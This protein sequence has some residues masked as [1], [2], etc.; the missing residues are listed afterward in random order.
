MRVHQGRRRHKVTVVILGLLAAATGSSGL[1]QTEVSRADSPAMSA[2]RPSPARP[3]V[4]RVLAFE[5]NDGQIDGAARFIAH[6]RGAT[7]FLTTSGLVVAPVEERG[8]RSDALRMTLVGAST[9]G[10]FTVSQPLQGRANY[11]VG[12]D[13]AKWRTGIPT[14]DRVTERAV[15]PGIDIAYYGVDGQVEY[16]FLVAPGADPGA[17]ELS[18]DGAERISLD[19]AG[20]LVLATTQGTLRVKAPQAYQEHVGNR[21]H[22]DA[23]FV[24]RANTVRFEVGAF[25]RTQTLVIDPVIAYSSY[26]GGGND[27]GLNCCGHTIGR[28]IKTDAA[29]NI[30]ITGHQVQNNAFP[31]TITHGTEGE[32][33]VTKFTPD[34]ATLLFSAVIGGTGSDHALDMTVDAAGNAYVVGQS[35]SANDFPITASAFQQTFGGVQDAVV[36]KLSPDGSSLLYSSFLGG[37]GRDG[38]RRIAIDPAGNAYVMGEPAAGFPLVGNPYQTT[39]PGQSDLFVAKVNAAG[40]GLVYSTLLG[41]SRDDHF[42]GDI[43]VDASG[44]AYIA[45]GTNGTD[46]PTTPGAF[47]TTKT[48]F[49]VEG[50]IVKLSPDGS[51]LVFA[52]LLGGADGADLINGI[53]LDAAGNIY[54]AGFTEV[55]DFPVAGTPFQPVKGPDSLGTTRPDAFVAKLDPTLSMMIAA[56]YLGGSD[57]DVATGIALDANANV[58]VA[59]ETFSFDF[60]THQPFQAVHAGGSVDA[61]VTKLSPALS[62]LVYSSYLGGSGVESGE[63]TDPPCCPNTY[64]G[65]DA[66]GNVLLTGRT[67]SLDFPVT[68]DA[69]Q[70]QR[71]GPTNAYIVRIIETLTVAVDIKPG[72]FP[73]SINLGSNGTVPVAILSTATFDATTVN[74]LTVTLAS[75]SVRLRGNGAPQAAEQDVNN[76]GRLDLVVHVNTEALQLTNVDTLAEVKGETYSGQAIQGSDSVRIVN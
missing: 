7:V 76:D 73:N 26:F 63:T 11:F 40:T 51:S 35:D 1:A 9:E 29:G 22:V 45:G 56:T 34:G 2:P 67:S 31:T 25:D 32:I 42:G 10:G 47:D 49:S 24:L 66:S 54:V 48:D 44:H 5:R 61:F 57:R 15:Y 21:R 28:S 58:V 53:D 18:F 72:S 17:I 13:P 4:R 46:F 52:T 39:L 62:S 69:Y 33:F 64:L 43:A 36:L 50:F 65:L 23:R 12:S 60:P 30:Y 70:S 6:A 37:P 59:G 16:D 19:Q 38:G 14:F 71:L 55:T 8:S 20:D 75:A 3:A 41:S 74:P 68:A 27:V